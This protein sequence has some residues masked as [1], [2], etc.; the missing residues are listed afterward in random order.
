MPIAAGVNHV[1]ATRP[2]PVTEPTSA[3]ATTQPSHSRGDRA[4][5]TGAGRT[6]AEEGTTCSA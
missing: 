3:V 1:P 5:G 4:M 6:S 2:T